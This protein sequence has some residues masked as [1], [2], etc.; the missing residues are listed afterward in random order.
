MEEV[1][2]FSGCNDACGDEEIVGTCR[3]RHYCHDGSAR[4][5]CFAAVIEGDGELYSSHDRAEKRWS[6]VP[7][8][9][10]SYGQVMTFRRD[11]GRHRFH[12]IFK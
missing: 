8:M 5:V 3:R 10:D 1:K 11:Q 9:L 4:G 2:N 12:F 6:V 7:V